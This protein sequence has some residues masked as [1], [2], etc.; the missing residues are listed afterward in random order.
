MPQNLS[1]FRTT[2]TCPK[3]GDDACAIVEI[4]TVLAGV[5]PNIEGVEYLGDSRVLWD[6]QRPDLVDDRIQWVCE[7]GH[8][9]TA[10]T[11]GRASRPHE[12]GDTLPEPDPSD[13]TAPLTRCL[14]C[15]GARVQVVGAWT[16]PNTDEVVDTER[17][18]ERDI[19]IPEH[20]TWCLDCEAGHGVFWGPDGSPDGAWPPAPS[21]PAVQLILT[22]EHGSGYCDLCRD[23]PFPPCGDDVIAPDGKTYRCT[24]PQ[25]HNGPCIACDSSTDPSGH[26]LAVGPWP[27]GGAR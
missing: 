15:Y 10:D 5:L 21:E 7:S 19:D 25:G 13:P 17:V 3:C 26:P 6:E 27:K 20:F 14:G 9:W 24:R 16:D 8:D 23:F 18:F 22:D 4:T 11:D 12:A 2:P 1:D